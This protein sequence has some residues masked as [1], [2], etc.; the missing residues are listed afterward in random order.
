MAT[1]AMSENPIRYPTSH[2]LTDFVDPFIGT[3]G[4]GFGAGSINPGPQ[5]PGGAMRLGPDTTW[6]LGSD[7]SPSS[8]ELW[9]PFQHF[10][11][12]THEDDNYIRAF[13]HTHLVGAGIPDWGNFGVQAFRAP[14]TNATIQTTATQPKYKTRFSHS[15]ETAAVG[16]YSVFLEDPEAFAELTVGGTHSGV[17]RYT[18]EPSATGNTNDCVIIFDPAHSSSDG[19]APVRIASVNVTLANGGQTVVIQS[20][21]NMQGGLSGR[22][23]GGVPIFF[24]GEVEATAALNGVGLWQNGALS[25]SYP[26][27]SFPAGGVNASTTIGN[28]GAYLMFPPATSTTGPVVVTLRA[29]ISFVDVAGARKNLYSQQTAPSAGIATTSLR[30]QKRGKKRQSKAITAAT[31]IAN[32]LSFEA[33]RAQ[34]VT[35]WEEALGRVQVSLPADEPAVNASVS[36]TVFYTGLY[37]A[38]FA[39]TIY[40]EADGRYA[41]MDGNIHSLSASDMANGV[42][43]RSDMS[44]WD[45]YRTQAPLM[46]LVRPEAANDIQRSLLLMYQQG[47]RL[48]RWP[49]ANVYTGCMVGSHSLIILADYLQKQGL[50][51]Q[52]LNTTAIYQ[53]ALNAL[54]TQDDANWISFGYLPIEE[55]TT[56]ASN[57]IEYTQDDAAGAVIATFAG[58]TA[59]ANIWKQRS[60]NYRNVFSVMDVNHTSPNSG[61]YASSPIPCSRHANGSFD[62][63]ASPDVPYPFNGGGYIE[64]DALQYQTAV[65]QGMLDGSLVKLWPSPQAFVASLD[66]LMQ[67][68]TSWPLGNDLPN[69]F[70]WPGNEP[71]LL[72]PWQ[73]AAAGPQYAPRTQ[74]WSRF[75]LDYYYRQP[76]ANGKPWQGIPGNDDFGTMSSNAVWTNLGIYPLSGQGAYALGA[77]VVASANVTVPANLFCGSGSAGT[78]IMALQII[79]HNASSGNAF[80][81]SV[82][83]NG[84]LTT[85]GFLAHDDLFPYPIKNACPGS[86]EAYSPALLEFWM[87]DTPSYPI[88][89]Y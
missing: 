82:A 67:N 22:G 28:V 46:N 59:Q 53:A 14:V 2:S 76:V 9:L 17:H 43:Y 83:A 10:G 60:Y 55:S 27:S 44:I 13:S 56:A 58:Q 36:L 33:L 52:T 79:A 62:C 11:G 77:P 8:L 48:P 72:Q 85:S 16:Y 84:K 49:L 88:D 80:T 51:P 12:Y 39:P 50:M 66:L 45:I 29:G 40:S 47:G 61:K 32:W 37:H 26:A 7:T 78:S 86:G 71:S 34:T 74:Y 89:A 54:T 64:G 5:V 38:L 65:P 6:V 42:N 35:E 73:Y 68:Q 81:N 15:N 31:T 63:P 87:T 41:G 75:V 30:K 1:A 3:G 18:F 19:S 20:A 21:L 25:P 4:I 57:T 24:Y 23:N 69:P 70:L